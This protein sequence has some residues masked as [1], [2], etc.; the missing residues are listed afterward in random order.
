[1]TTDDIT[2][3]REHASNLRNFCR[4]ASESEDEATRRRNNEK[5][6]AA[7]FIESL[8]SQV[9]KITAEMDD[10]KSSVIAFGAP[11]CVQY[12]KDHGLP[13]HHLDPV[14]YDCLKRA[15]ARMDSF[16]RAIIKNEYLDNA[17]DPRD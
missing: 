13:D 4:Y 2:K 5:K 8:V 11:W 15:G 17:T 12:A 9:E 3:A 16:T 7:D 14:H 6:A 1:M 10:L